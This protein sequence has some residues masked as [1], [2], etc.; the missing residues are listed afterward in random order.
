VKQTKALLDSRE[1]DGEAI[2]AFNFTL[3]GE[4]MDSLSSS[5]SLVNDVHVLKTED[6]IV[7]VAALIELYKAGRRAIDKVY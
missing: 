1:L 5:I 7:Y 4:G 3:D 2:A 6:S